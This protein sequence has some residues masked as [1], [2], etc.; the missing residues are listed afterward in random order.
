MSFPS[1]RAHSTP[2]ASKSRLNYLLDAPSPAPLSHLSLSDAPRRPRSPAP[3][4]SLRARSADGALQSRLPPL[5]P[6]PRLHTHPGLPAFPNQLRPPRYATPS[7]QSS[8]S[9]H[10]PPP[11]PDAAHH[12]AHHHAHHGLAPPMMRE[13]STSALSEAVASQRMPSGP[14]ASSC[15]LGVGSPLGHAPHPHIPASP[16]H[17]L[18]RRPNEKADFHDKRELRRMKNRISAARSRQR[19]SDNYESLQR[20]LS[21]ARAEL[22]EA[23]N[24]IQSLTLQVEKRGRAAP[25]TVAVPQDLKRV[26]HRDY[27]S[28]DEI[29]DMLRDYARHRC[30]P[31]HS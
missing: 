8:S 5:S 10:A 21:D 16:P 22:A 23:R 3:P 11:A 12:H 7:P 18:G 1:S 17:P 27:M 13:P 14:F 4:P 15:S 2:S 6:P 19:K 20:E 25:F 31:A 9:P 30:N 24:V 28:V 29:M 26:I